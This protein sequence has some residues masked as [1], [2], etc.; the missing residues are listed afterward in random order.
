LFK[1][2]PSITNLVGLCFFVRVWSVKGGDHTVQLKAHPGPITFN[3]LG[4]SGTE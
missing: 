2:S 1:E 4:A 3:G